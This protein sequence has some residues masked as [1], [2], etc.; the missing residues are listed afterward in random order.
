MGVGTE[1]AGAAGAGGVVTVSEAG[2]PP[3]G[4]NVTAA[5]VSVSESTAGGGGK[6]HPGAEVGGGASGEVGRTRASSSSNVRSVLIT[7]SSGLTVGAS[8]AVGE[9]TGT[10]GGAADALPGAELLD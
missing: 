7:G 3:A 9:E 8:G 5:K 6:S 2:T 1:L 10:V 4:D